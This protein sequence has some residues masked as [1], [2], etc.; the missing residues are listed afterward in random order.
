MRSAASVLSR[1]ILAG[2]LLFASVAGVLGEERSE[3]DPS[4]DA[5]REWFSL[6]NGRTEFE[7]SDPALLPSQLVLAAEQSACRF[8]DRIKEVPV[9]FISVE[10]RRLA[11]VFCNFGIGVSHRVFDLSN[12][13]KPK[14]V[15]LPFLAYP[16]GFGTTANP[17]WI[18]WKREAGV[19]QAETGSDTCPGS[20]LRHTYRLDAIRGSATFVIVRVEAQQGVC[21]DHGDVLTTIWE[22]PQWSLLAKPGAR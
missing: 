7:V 9:R 2:M 15:E 18:T 10:R 21:G 1:L 22:A 13:R 4:R 12:L 6:A 14:L 8:E 11:L 17:G 5:R 16:D 3:P 19:F 20:L